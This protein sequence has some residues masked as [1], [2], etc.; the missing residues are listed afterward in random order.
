MPAAMDTMKKLLKKVRVSTLVYAAL[1]AVVLVFAAS[2]VTTYAFPQSSALAERLKDTLPYPAVIISYQDG[3]TYRTL[4]ENMSAIRRFYEAQDFSKVGLRVDFSTDEGKKRFKVREKEVLNKM[5]EDEAIKILAGDRGI[6]ISASEAAQAVSRKFEE[7]G[8]GEEVK[9]DLDRLY[10]WTLDDFEEKVVIPSLYQ[11]KLQTSFAKEV[12][13]VSEGKKK[14]GSA[15]EALRAGK[16]F[17][18]VA[19]QYS[20][21]STAQEGGSLG[22][23]ALEDLA[24]E[25]RPAVAAQK[26]GVPGDVVESGLGF[27]IIFVEEI[28]KEDQKQLYRL[29]QIFSRKVTFADWLA[30]KMRG[31][32]IVVLSPE[33][34]WNS[35]EAR[36]EFKKQEW[37][38]FEKNIFEKE[39]GDAAFFF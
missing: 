37:R 23:F 38:D 14:I 29:S 24:L 33:Y 8:S 20:E 4:A 17:A 31:L 19:R 15:Q 7:Y 26:I 10:G 22:W 5:I 30:L 27:H 28:K 32:S 12:D 13:A 1:I 25:L 34:R 21:G 16:P 39:D 35:D 11:E 6:R 3:I 9:K 36:V 18:E 2:L